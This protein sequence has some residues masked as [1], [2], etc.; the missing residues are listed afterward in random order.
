MFLEEDYATLNLK[1]VIWK[2][3]A[4]K[5]LSQKDRWKCPLHSA[6]SLGSNIQ[7]QVEIRPVYQ[8]P[9]EP[10][11]TQYLELWCDLNFH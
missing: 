4:T 8:E 10:I 9:K 1:L 11:I 7:P 3:P 5:I 2:Q 6:S